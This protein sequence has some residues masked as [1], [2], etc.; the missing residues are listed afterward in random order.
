M[1]ILLTLP[2]Q[3]GA[4]M[5][6]DQEKIDDDAHRQKMVINRASWSLEWHL[7]CDL[8]TLI[9]HVANQRGPLHSTSTILAL[10]V[11]S[12]RHLA[13]VSCP[14]EFVE[15]SP[16]GGGRGRDQ[17]WFRLLSPHPPPTSDHD[18][19]ITPRPTTLS[20]TV[21]WHDVMPSSTILLPRLSPRY[22][23]AAI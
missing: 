16:R 6:T 18:R 22:E 7:A 21:P 3:A 19:I 8:M 23:I 2:S 20:A 14:D 12:M 10:F 15:A 1:L 5:Q 17:G 4:V 9:L 11:P 13:H